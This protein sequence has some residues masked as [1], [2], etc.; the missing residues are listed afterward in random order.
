MKK[1]LFII[2]CLFLPFIS[3]QAAEVHAILIADTMDGVLHFQTNIDMMQ[4]AAK[5]IAAKTGYDLHVAM[6][7][8]QEVRIKNIL[9][10]IE[11]LEIQPEDVIFFY[12][13]NH[14][15]RKQNKNTQ[16]PSLIFSMDRALYPEQS[17]LDFA[18]LNKALKNKNA[19]LLVSMTEACNVVESE[20]KFFKDDEEDDKD[21]PTEAE[22]EF[23]RNKYEQKHGPTLEYR[24]AHNDELLQRLKERADDEEIELYR[25][26]FVEHYGSIIISSSSPGEAALFGLF[27]PIFLNN[28]RETLFFYNDEGRHNPWKAILEKTKQ[29]VMQK[30]ALEERGVKQKTQT[31]QYDLQLKYKNGKCY[32]FP[33]YTSD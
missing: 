30:Y 14:G 22:R 6:F 1:L 4:R 20:E 28:F 10:Y 8:E 11:K 31:V 5:G 33:T 21:A 26:L 29:E 13:N 32:Y 7:E 9:D 24:L 3:I 18:L 19:H 25:C 17:T 2:S 12:I 15:S 16:W 23:F 27:T